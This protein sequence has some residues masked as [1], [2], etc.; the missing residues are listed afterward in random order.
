VVQTFSGLASGSFIAPDHE[1]PS[2]L[3]LRLTV[4]DA[5]NLT[6]MKSVLLYPQTVNLTLA[7][8][9][10]GG[11]ILLNG[12]GGASPRTSTVIAGSLN[13]VSTMVPGDG[14]RFVGWAVDGLAAG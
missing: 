3:E 10:A 12:A 13:T 2:H 4:R 8:D 5:G 6:N 7:T 14:Q 9:P 1:Y 11:D